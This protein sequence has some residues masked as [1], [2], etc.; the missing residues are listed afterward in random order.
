MARQRIRPIL[1]FRRRSARF[2]RVGRNTYKLANRLMDD[3]L[4]GGIKIVAGWTGLENCGT[5]L[6]YKM[7]VGYDGGTPYGARAPNTVPET[8]FGSFAPTNV[9]GLLIYEVSADTGNINVIR[10]G[11]AGDE[12]IQGSVNADVSFQGFAGNPVNY[13]WN[14]GNLYYQITA[15]NQALTDYIISLDGQRISIDVGAV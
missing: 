8:E 13:T 2:Q 10:F 7:V 4:F 11:D 5:L 14:G 15:S 6:T 9:N 1:L 3:T 12:Q